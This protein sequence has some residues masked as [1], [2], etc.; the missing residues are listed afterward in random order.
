MDMASNRRAARQAVMCKEISKNRRLILMWMLS[1]EELAANE[2]ADRVGSS[3]EN[4]AY[5][6]RQLEKS[7]MITARRA[8]PKIYYHTVDHELLRASLVSTG[9]CD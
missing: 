6:L 7:G 9:A 4:I 5:Y 3:Q 8:G 1:K 2:L